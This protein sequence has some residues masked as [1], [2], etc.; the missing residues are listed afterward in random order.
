MD[1]R[2]FG[3]AYNSTKNFEPV[4]NKQLENLSIGRMDESEEIL[5]RLMNDE[6]FRNIASSHLMRAV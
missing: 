6:V 4:F 2:C 3:S 1:E 5:V